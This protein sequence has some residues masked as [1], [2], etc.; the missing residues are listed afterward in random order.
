MLSSRI[1]NVDGVFTAMGYLT[2]IGALDGVF[3]LRNHRGVDL[4]D[5]LDGWFCLG[6]NSRGSANDGVEGIVN[7]LHKFPYDYATGVCKNP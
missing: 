2:R 3:S 7:G 5:F 6:N 1:T 4:V